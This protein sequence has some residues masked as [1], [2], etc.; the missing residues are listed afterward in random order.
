MRVSNREEEEPMYHRIVVPLDG[1]ELAERA[2]KPAAELAERFGSTITLVTVVENDAESLDVK[3]H[4]RDTAARLGR[5]P[6]DIRVEVGDDPGREI[7]RVIH[8]RPDT[9][10][11]MGSRGRSGLG[12]AVLGS[13]AKHIMQGTDAPLVL[14][15]PRCREAPLSFA[16]LMA[17][18]DGSSVSEEILPL[19]ASW[20]SS[21]GMQL[22][23][24]HVVEPEAAEALAEAL[25]RFGLTPSDDVREDNYLRLVAGDLARGGV[26]A[27]WDVLHGHDPARAIVD[28]ANAQA[29][30]LL[31]LSTHGR[32]CW[33]RVAIGSTAAKV[34]HDSPCPV[35]VMRPRGLHD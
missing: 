25:E 9:L 20:A 7:L 26:E 24:A 27:N 11:C 30:S 14:V 4:L 1:S 17:C 35:L 29:L 22:W 10:V 13:V 18:V 15:G 2:V 23:L 32:S 8:E 28:Y 31:A 19:A 33:A 5:E 21:L 34:V 16:R 6:G 3:E 12:E